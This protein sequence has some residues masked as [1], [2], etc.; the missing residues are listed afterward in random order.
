MLS[1]VAKGTEFRI[2]IPLTH[3][4][5][6]ENTS[7]KIDPLKNPIISN[8]RVLVVDDNEHNRFLSETFLTRNG[9][10]VTSCSSAKKAINLLQ[11]GILYDLILMDVQMPIMSG[12]EAAVYIRS[13]LGL[14]IPNVA[15]SAHVLESEKALCFEAGMN[16][17][18]LKPYSEAELISY[19]GET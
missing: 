4:V 19:V 11:K 9:A 6:S 18:L 2:E 7:I 14:N 5:H 3:T 13:S 8:K 16:A 17:Y 10:I 12:I 15:C 1:E